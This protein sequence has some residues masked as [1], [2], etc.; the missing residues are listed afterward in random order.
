MIQTCRPCS[1]VKNIFMTVSWTAGKKDQDVLACM[2]YVYGC[3]GALSPRIKQSGREAGRSHLSSA[4]VKSVWSYTYNP[5]YV[6]MA[7][8]LVKHKDCTL[9]GFGIRPIVS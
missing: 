9:P 3:W 1:Y 7:W 8:Y 6:F 4:K 5:P 2:L